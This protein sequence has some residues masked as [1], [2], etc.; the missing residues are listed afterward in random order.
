MCELGAGEMLLAAKL[1][2]PKLLAGAASCLA[3]NAGA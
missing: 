2:L 3:S 1:P